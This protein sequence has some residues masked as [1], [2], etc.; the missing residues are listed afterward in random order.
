VR[1]LIDACVDPRVVELLD[2]HEFKT[3]HQLG[4]H[5]LKDHTLLSRVQGHFDVLVT[6]DRG[7]EFEHNLRKLRFGIV[8]FH[9]E[10]NKIEFYRPLAA[11]L[12]EAIDRLTPGEVIHV[13]SQGS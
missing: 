13:R 2:E 1:V 11:A 7:I 4:W 6:I 5:G 8:V 12:L 3:A 9:V 10:K